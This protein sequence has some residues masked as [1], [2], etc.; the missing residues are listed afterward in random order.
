MLKIYGD[1]MRFKVV[2]PELVFTETLQYEQ[3]HII[4]VKGRRQR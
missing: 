4:Q 2:G 1:K 3:W